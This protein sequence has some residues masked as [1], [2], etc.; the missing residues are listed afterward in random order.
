[1]SNLERFI[2]TINEH[3]GELEEEFSVS[4]IGLFGSYVRDDQDT[5]SDLDI[6]VEFSTPIS[7]L[8]FVSLKRTL[9]QLLGVNVDL[10]M[11]KGL[12]PRIG[13]RILSE[14]VYV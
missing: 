6:L 8:K 11:K 2:K 3:M 1:M 14:V 4:S 7:L 5:G 10:V 12:K 13:E 9:S